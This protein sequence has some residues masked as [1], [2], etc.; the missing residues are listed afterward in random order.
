MHT[1]CAVQLLKEFQEN[2]PTC[3]FK[4]ILLCM[5][6]LGTVGS[7]CILKKVI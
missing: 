6:E 7:E 5:Y 4:L 1:I 3:M 2:W